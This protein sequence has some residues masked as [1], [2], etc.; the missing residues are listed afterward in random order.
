MYQATRICALTLVAPFLL[1]DCATAQPS[2]RYHWSLEA[3]I[4]EAEAVV[5]GPIAKLHR[6]VIEEPNQRQPNGQYEY[7]PAVKVEE[8]LKGK[9]AGV[10]DDLHPKWSLGEDRT[11]EEWRKA[12]NKILWFLGPAPNERKKRVWQ[13]VVF[14]KKA[15]AE[16][17]FGGRREPPMYAMDF[18]LLKD[19]EAVLA[20]ARKYAEASTRILE[21]D[22]IRFGPPW[23]DLKVPVEPALEPLAKRLIATP[24]DFL[25][26]GQKLTPRERYQFRYSGVRLLRH[27]K[28]DANIALVKLLLDDPPEKFESSLVAQYPVRVKAFEVLLHWN[29]DAALPK[30][31]E[32]VTRIDLAKSDVAD[33]GL[34]RL[35]GLK[36]LETL[37]LSDTKITAQGLKNLAGLKKLT[38]IRLEERQMSDANLR[39]L[40]E[41]GL[42]H[43]VSAASADR[44]RPTSAL[45]VTSLSLCRGPLTDAGLKEL[46]ELKNLTWL[47]L[48]D[49]QV[50]DAGLKELAALKSLERLLLQG[51]RVSRA[52]VADL[53]KALPKCKIDY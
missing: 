4:A 12:G 50:T 49:T 46:A 44:K 43:A 16:D 21:S 29:V 13:M 7:A 15:P 39:A 36:N 47:D 18:T 20:H 1:A 22:T 23:N 27:F 37:E 5:V 40:R 51:N 8:V 30:S 26:K 33:A 6:R 2:H 9:L 38:T 24:Q 25:P 32:E 41:A 14:G 11:Y 17:L 31:P 53:Q 42:L 3:R 35:A 34:K 10:V 19:E 48:R 45:E 52:G 28:S